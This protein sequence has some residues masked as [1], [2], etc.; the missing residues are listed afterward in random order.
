MIRVRLLVMIFNQY[1][2]TVTR[3]ELFRIV[4][5]SRKRFAEVWFRIP[6]AACHAIRKSDDRHILENSGEIMSANYKI[7]FAASAKIE[8]GLAI[9]LQLAGQALPAGLAEAEPPKIISRAELGRGSGGERWCSAGSTSV[10]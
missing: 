5:A 4:T 10:G 6:Q 9:M 3:I 1:L 8:G 7:R 2:R